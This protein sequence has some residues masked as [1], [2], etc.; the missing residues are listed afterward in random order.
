MVR[1]GVTVIKICHHERSQLPS[2][3]KKKAVNPI[4]IIVGVKK[5]VVLELER[6]N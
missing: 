2:Q 6:P 1:D 3:E 4:E 5:H